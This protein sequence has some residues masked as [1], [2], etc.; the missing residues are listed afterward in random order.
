MQEKR[1]LT[2][3]VGTTAYNEENNIK[4]FL[5][6]L[7]IQNQ[8]TI[9]IKEIIIIS[10]GS[11]DHTAEI[12]KSFP[13]SRIKIII[14]HRRRG[15]NFRLNQLIEMF[16]GDILIIFDADVLLKNKMVIENL[17]CH[18]YNNGKIGLVGGNPQPLPAKTFPEKA[19]NNL[20]LARNIL[21][22]SIKNGHNVH[23]MWG[24]VFALSRKLAKKITIPYDVPA[25]TFI[26]FSCKK[27]KFEFYYEKKAVVLFRS[28][29]TVQDQIQRGAR[30][31][32]NKK[33]LS[34]YFDDQQINQEYAVSISLQIK[35]LISQLLKNPLAYLLMKYMHFQSLRKK[36]KTFDSKWTPILSTKKLK[37][38]K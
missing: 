2:I 34:K 27:Q 33:S 17:A 36:I 37:Y 38:D 10:D 32:I 12:A 9:R 16:S 28:P 8:K 7:C 3:S 30:F 22:E 26:Y 13:C 24:Q 15:H 19:V 4:L 35:M 11:T 1:I 23:G 29:Q 20:Y 18:F 21:K 25:D 5:E 14:D 6:S 31:L